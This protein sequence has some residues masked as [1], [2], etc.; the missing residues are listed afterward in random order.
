MTLSPS[1]S[2]FAAA[3]LLLVAASGTSAQPSA[4]D[5]LR[6]RSL[7]AGC[8]ACHGTDGHAVQGA[9]TAALAGLPS[10]YIVAQ[11]AAFRDGR[12][13]ATVM[14]QVAKGYTPEQVAQLAGYFAAQPKVQR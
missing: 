2:R 11:M 4:A 10:D 7:A 3:G 12:R 13:P 9:G 14:H 8:S 6:L 1:L 5:A